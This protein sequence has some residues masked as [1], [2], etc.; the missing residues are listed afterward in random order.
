MPTP[1]QPNNMA[2]LQRRTDLSLQGTVAV[3]ILVIM[4][5]SGIL[6][7]VIFVKICSKQRRRE[8]AMRRMQEENAPF[9][10]AQYTAPPGAPSNTSSPPYG[11]QE[12]VSTELHNEPRYQYNGPLELQGN[13]RPEALPAQQLDGHT[14]AVSAAIARKHVLGMRKLTC[15]SQHLV[16]A[17]LLNYLRILCRAS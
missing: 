9:V 16:M 1:N 8:R 6:C 11:G 2:P 7:T 13:E 4:F 5:L 3:I 12:Q 14:A 15:C 10:V 17:P